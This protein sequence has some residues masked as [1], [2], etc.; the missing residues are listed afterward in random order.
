MNK[1]LKIPGFIFK[2]L[3]SHNT[4]K[5][6][7]KRQDDVL[8]FEFPVFDKDMVLDTA[9]KLAAKKR[10]A[11]DRDLD[12]L[13]EIM[14][15]VGDLW[16]DP[17]YDLRKE[18]LEVIPMMTGQSRE[19]CEIEF[20]G[21]IRL[22]NKKN[23]ELQLLGEIGGKEYLED[24]IQKG[25][26]RLHAQPR[27]VVCHNLAGNSFGLGPTSLSY[28]L[29]TKNVNLLK[30]SHQEPFVTVRLCESIAEV[31]KKLAKEIAAI[32][33]KGSRGDIYDELFN[34]GNIDCVIAW[35][36]IFS[37]ED[38]RR[39][40][41]RYGIKI[42]DNGPKM[43]FSVVSEDIF[44]NEQTMQEIAQKIAI[45]VVFWNQRACLSPRVIY[46][47]DKP[48]E[49]AIMGDTNNNSSTEED[50]TIESSSLNNLFADSIDKFSHTNEINGYNMG[51]LMKRSVKTL[52]NKISE[53]SP[54]G[55]AKM[56][57]NGLRNADE[58]LPRANLSQTDSLEM[59]RKRE[60][61]F[62]NYVT[63]NKATI[64]YPPKNK[65]DWTV[66]YMRS[67]PTMN[68]IDMCQDRFLICCRLSSVQDLIYN[69]RREEMQQY[70]QTAAIYGEDSFVKEVAEELSLLGA[71]RFPRA[72]E[73]NSNDFGL[74]WDGKYVLQDMIR[75][76]YICFPQEE[77]NSKSKIQSP[78]FKG[79]TYP[80]R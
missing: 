44:N 52:R 58:I 76:C 20:L 39:R 41:N 25:S 62:I 77:L 72:G 5:E 1:K 40:A 70:L 59:Q 3:Y 54:L 79:R 4:T 74:P 60:Y 31:D 16:M 17:N 9:E 33:W 13:F 32:Y 45:D 10:R 46:I 71:F 78:L 48:L 64:L 68:E 24:W 75:W 27:G 22:W 66:V 14:D 7:V 2:P 50:E 47:I 55:F 6:V 12:E 49:S 65:L 56:L 28:G 43:S 15:Q 80:E 11:H 19:L 26:A 57:A 8:E 21:T 67:L 37:I 30:L 18:V 69:I 42:I 53:L 36:A 35:G 29:I 51:A 73:H 34:S 61:F 63:Q 23:S 38:I